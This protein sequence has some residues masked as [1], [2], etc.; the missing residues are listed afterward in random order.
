MHLNIQRPP[1]KKG[2]YLPLR[3]PVSPGDQILDNIVGAGINPVRP[4]KR[5]GVRI[6]VI[7]KFD[8]TPGI[9]DL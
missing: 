1:A 8:H 7:K 6:Q 2:F 3:L 9:V 5:I 4:G